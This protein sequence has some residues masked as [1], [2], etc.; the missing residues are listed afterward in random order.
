M[1][2]AGVS[3]CVYRTRKAVWPGTGEL[4]SG[5]SCQRGVDS[6]EATEDRGTHHRFK[7]LRTFH[8][9]E[10]K[11]SNGHNSIFTHL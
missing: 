8:E 3:D 7:E 4:M 10:T 11:L 9:Q 5:R 6:V 1:A 2:S